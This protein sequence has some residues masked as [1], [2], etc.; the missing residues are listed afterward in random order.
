MK[1][2]IMQLSLSTQYL[3]QVHTKHILLAV[4]LLMQTT[5]TLYYKLLV[6]L[7]EQLQ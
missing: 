3:A 4:N 1:T 7:M 6:V 5:Q 2:S